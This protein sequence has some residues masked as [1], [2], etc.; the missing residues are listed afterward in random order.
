MG[1]FHPYAAAGVCGPRLKLL[2]QS[3]S[4]ILFF[5]SI[6]NKYFDTSVNRDQVDKVMVLGRESRP[7]DYFGTAWNT[8][9]TFLDISLAI[10]SRQLLFHVNCSVCVPMMFFLL[11]MFIKC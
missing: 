4:H 5:G 11:A 7:D 10:L 9:M 2:V 8:I 1:R 3:I 6:S